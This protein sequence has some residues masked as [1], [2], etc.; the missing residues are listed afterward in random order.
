MR[1][2]LLTFTTYFVRQAYV[3]T[4]CAIVSKT[5]EAALRLAVASEP[6]QAS[7]QR[8]DRLALSGPAYHASSIRHMLAD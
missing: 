2:T 1:R 4:L 3:R 6:L 8:F 5:Y 7:W